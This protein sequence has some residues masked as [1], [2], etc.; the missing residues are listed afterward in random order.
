MAP[1]TSTTVVWVHG[2]ALSPNNSALLA[3]PNAPAVFVFDDA[4][5]TRMQISLKRIVF[6]YECLLELPVHIRRGDPAQELT[7]FAQKHEGTKIATT[8]SPS[9]GFRHICRTLEL[10]GLEIEIHAPEP[11]VTLPEHT[12]L[13][14]FSRYWKIAQKRLA[15]QDAS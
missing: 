1:V 11:F 13:R 5:L 15:K 14:R 3:Y 12:D 2:D 4:L 8:P 7:S 9:P 6:M 10:S